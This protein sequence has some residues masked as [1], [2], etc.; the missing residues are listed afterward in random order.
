MQE[1]PCIRNG[2]MSF[3][4]KKILNAMV[5]GDKKRFGRDKAEAGAAKKKRQARYAAMCKEYMN[6]NPTAKRCKL[7]PKQDAELKA[8]VTEVQ[9]ALNRQSDPNYKKTE[10]DKSTIQKAYNKPKMS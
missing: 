6:K 5:N 2:K 10:A 8:M 9:G 7:T 4:E 1:G 3:N